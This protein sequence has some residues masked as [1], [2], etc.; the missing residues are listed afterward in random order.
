M[1]SRGAVHLALGG[2]DKKKLNRKKQG[3]FYGNFPR[4]HFKN[5]AYEA[6]NFKISAVE[7][8]FLYLCKANIFNI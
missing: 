3:L 1:N 5:A 2:V 6:W 8:V 4:P 7:S